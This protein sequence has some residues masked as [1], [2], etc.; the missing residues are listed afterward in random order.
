MDIVQRYKEL[1]SMGVGESRSKVQAATEH[2]RSTGGYVSA[3]TE[4]L[5]RELRIAHNTPTRP[6]GLL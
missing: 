1:R 2:A 4:K 3:S 6:G 5:E